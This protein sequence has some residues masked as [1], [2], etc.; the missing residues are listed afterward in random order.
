[1]R[2]NL[3]NSGGKLREAVRQFRHQE[4]LRKLTMHM[5]ATRFGGWKEENGK[6]VNESGREASKAN[7]VL[8]EGGRLVPKG[9]KLC[10]YKI[11]W[12]LEVN[13]YC[14]QQG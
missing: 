1:M 2:D 5:V 8:L 9:G 7:W 12:L 4:S 3:A 13:Q 11:D 14:E 10:D 6:Y